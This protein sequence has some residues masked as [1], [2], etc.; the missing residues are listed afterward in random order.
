MFNKPTL[1]EDTRVT[2]VALNA[3]VNIQ[4]LVVCIDN[5]LQNNAKSFIFSSETLNR[6]LSRF[7]DC[8]AFSVD[9]LPLSWENSVVL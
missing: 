6:A 9:L 7:Q 4:K 1:S 2:H 8:N 3:D 5:C